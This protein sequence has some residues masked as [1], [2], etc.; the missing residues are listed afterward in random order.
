MSD[1]STAADS[2]PR[3]KKPEVIEDAV[4]V[5][6]TSST[7]V[8]VETVHA[9]ET[10]PVVAT[11]D[12]AATETTTPS[13]RVVY[14]HVPP[15]PKKL[16]NRGVGTLLAVLAAVVFTLVLAAATVAVGFI[17]TRSF[18]V[19]FLTRG[20]FYIPALFFVVAFVLL[21]LIVNR[22]NWG[23]YIVGSILVGLAVYFG[24]IGLGLVSTGVV[25]QS[26]AEASGRF[27]RELGNPFIILSGLLAR[28][29]SMWFGV[30][31][32]R[33]GRRL[34]ARN[35]EAR[36]EYDRDIAQ[37]KAESERTAPAA[38]TAV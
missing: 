1:D 9:T 17:A 26:P 38:A 37:K 3:S 5:D 36:A 33:R 23:A 15:A 19:A 30:A 11:T 12:P 35:V 34:K 16:G 29:V 2:K 10:E 18:S 4:I 28:E 8:V 7:P 13:E 27:A 21:V 6:D 25:L 24:T 14:V 22:A 32:S 20:E 31:I